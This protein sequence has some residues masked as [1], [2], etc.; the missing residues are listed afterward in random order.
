MNQIIDGLWITD[1]ETVREQPIDV[2]VVITVCQD[3][4]EDNV[5]CEY[6]HYN[7][8]D[9]PTDL[10]RGEFTYDLFS[11]AVDSAFEHLEDGKE[12]LV[13]CHVGQSRSAAVCAAVIGRMG[14]NIRP[15]EAI[16]MV[17]NARA[18]ANPIRDLVDFVERYIEENT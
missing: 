10:L 4:V 13:H 14:G 1:I 9:G 15:H 3:S 7:L 2:D 11:D 12:V 8:T 17:R 18:S 5:G 16:G 6:E